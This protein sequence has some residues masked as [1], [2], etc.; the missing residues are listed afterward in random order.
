VVLVSEGNLFLQSALE[1]HPWMQVSRIGPEAFEAERPGTDIWV[2]DRYVPPKLPAG[3]CLFVDP[4]KDSALWAVGEELKNPLVSET[5]G[6]SVLL[7]HVDLDSCTIHRA[8]AIT[9]KRQA[10]VLLRSFGNPLLLEWPGRQAG[11]LGA[12]RVVLAIDINQSDLPWR[13]AF[14]ILVQN[15][16]NEFAGQSDEPAVSKAEGGES[17]LWLG[18]D[19]AGAETPPSGVLASVRSLPWWVV[20]VV[21]AVT[22][23]VAEWGLHQRRRID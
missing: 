8:R 15:V 22:L 16:L 11:E 7:R 18:M 1:S 17:N 4:Q 21:L 3:P 10:R 19:L 5:D 13:T 20:L 9:A 2:F 23:N 6:G 12:G 14:P